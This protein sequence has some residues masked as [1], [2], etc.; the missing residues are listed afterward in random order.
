MS[1]KS[2]MCTMRIVGSEIKVM[3]VGIRLI[4]L[5]LI[6]TAV[7]AIL[8]IAVQVLSGPSRYASADTNCNKV[9]RD[10]QYAFSEA[11]DK[12]IDS[13]EELRVLVN[14]TFSQPLIDYPECRQELQNVLN[15]NATNDPS[16][17]FPYPKSADPKNFVLGPVSWWWD[18][19][20]SDLLGGNTLLMLF[21]GWEIFLMPFPPLFALALFILPLPFK[22]MTSLRKKKST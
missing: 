12:E 13:P 22:L 3:L 8:L 15:W 10:V 14:Q 18:K 20:Y 21:V 16:I 19:I 4:M 17:P 11:F 6:R 5:R 9:A 1:N 7:V 2:R